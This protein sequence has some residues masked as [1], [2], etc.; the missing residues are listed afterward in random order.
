MLRLAIERGDH[1]PRHGLPDPEAAACVTEVLLVLAQDDQVFRGDAGPA[2]LLWIAT[3]VLLG[4]AAAISLRAGMPNI[5]I[6]AIA[7]AAGADYAWLV[8]V[9]GHPFSEALAM[10]LAGGALAGLVIALFS[11]AFGVPSWAV[12]LGVAGAL[13]GLVPALAGSDARPSRKSRR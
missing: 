12:S 4:S 1:C 6:G 8:R 2:V 11:T 5:A 9:E 13:S 7:I 10:A 3:A